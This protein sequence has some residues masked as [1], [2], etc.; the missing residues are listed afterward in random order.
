MSERWIE[1]PTCHTGYQASRLGVS[2]DKTK[3]ITIVCQVCKQAFDTNVVV[4][5]TWEQ[6]SRWNPFRE[7]VTTMQI[8]SNPRVA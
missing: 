2:L 4:T 6:K 7:E 5:T 8:T 1:C 3:Q